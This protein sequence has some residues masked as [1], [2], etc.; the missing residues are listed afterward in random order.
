MDNAQDV[1]PQTVTSA[2]FVLTNQGMEDGEQCCVKRKCIR[3]AK[4]D[5]DIQNALRELYSSTNGKGILQFSPI[6]FF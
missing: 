3:T 2:S 5:S 6:D 1:M 4:T